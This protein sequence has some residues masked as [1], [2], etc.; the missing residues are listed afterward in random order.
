MIIR[1][2]GNK[3]SMDYSVGLFQKQA[4][5]D[6]SEKNFLENFEKFL[7]KTSVTKSFIV[8]NS[9]VTSIFGYFKSK[10]C[11]QSPLFFSSRIWVYLEENFQGVFRA[12]VAI[13]S[14]SQVSLSNTL[15]V[16]HFTL[17]LVD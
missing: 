5:K 7:R 1:I 17:M 12:E 10:N 8:N 16:V 14:C 11:Q 15:E 2:N 9:S 3:E 13:W 4:S 6:V